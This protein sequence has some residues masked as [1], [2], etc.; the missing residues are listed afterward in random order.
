M[1]FSGS[2]DGLGRRASV[3]LYM[4]ETTAADSNRRPPRCRVTLLSGESRLWTFTDFDAACWI[5]GPPQAETR[6]QGSRSPAVESGTCYGYFTPA[7]R[8]LTAG[9]ASSCSSSSMSLF[10]MTMTRQ[11]TP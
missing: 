11:L 9:G 10:S 1:L 5:N 7:E 4:N 6:P 3:G 2:T 8:L